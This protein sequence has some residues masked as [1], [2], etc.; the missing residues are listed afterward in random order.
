MNIKAYR[1]EVAYGKNNGSLMA[2]QPFKKDGKEIIF[3]DREAAI[4]IANTEFKAISGLKLD[5]FSVATGHEI[6]YGLE[7][8][9][10]ENDPD[11]FEDYENHK[12]DDWWQFKVIECEV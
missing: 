11:K 10:V 3:L 6:A 4:N 9:W 12:N 7:Y 8:Y 1:I 5:D 2:N